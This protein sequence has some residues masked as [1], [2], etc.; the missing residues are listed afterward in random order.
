VTVTKWGGD[1]GRTLC[2]LP[3][4]LGATG[5]ALNANR[6]VASVLTAPE[7]PVELW[8]IEPSGCRRLTLSEPIALS[9]L[10]VPLLSPDGSSVAVLTAGALHL[11]DVAEGQV[12][13]IPL[14]HLSISLYAWDQDGLMLF[15]EK[16][17]RHLRVSGDG[18]LSVMLDPVLRSRDGAYRATL[19]EGEIAAGANRRFVPKVRADLRAITNARGVAPRRIGA[20]GLELAGN[21]PLVLDLAT[22]RTR[23]LLDGESQIVCES[24]NGAHLMFFGPIWPSEGRPRR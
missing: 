15:E 11:I 7:G 19:L 24:P 6:G 20:H 8:I 14:E 18:A 22:L 3:G 17:H 9:Q 4:E 2:T 16:Q 12:R 23:P 1:L 21:G 5:Q 10:D 13:K